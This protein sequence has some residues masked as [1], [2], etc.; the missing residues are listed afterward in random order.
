[1]SSASRS[2][3]PEP[4]LELFPEGT[5]LDAA[6]E[7]MVGG[8][9]ATELAATFGTPALII[10]EAALR[11]RVRRYAE[12]LAARWPNSMVI[13]ASKSLPHTAMYRLMSEE[14]LGID[15]AGSGELFM[16][17][18][19]D[20]DP[21]TLVL[22]GNAKTDHEI[23]MAVKAGVGTIVVDSFDDIDR[24]ERFV[25]GEQGVLVRLRPGIMPHTHAAIATG[26]ED[27]KFGLSLPDAK[28]AVDRLRGSDKLRLD[29]VHVHV[30][31]QILDTE[32]FARAVEAVAE[33]GEYAVY[34][35][36]GGL[37]ARYT[38]DDQP[39]S[40]EDYLDTLTETA[41]KLLPPEARLLI[42]PGRSL[43]AE[44]G[45]TL[46]RVTTVKR[47]SRTF[48]AVDGGMSD[49]LEVSLYGQRFEATVVD[50]V[51]GGELCALVGKHCESGDQ[52]IDSV[53]LRDPHAGDV[54]AVPVTGAYCLTMANNYNG[55]C[56]PPI[57]F[58]NNGVP[59]MIV[60]RET[61]DD[62]LRRDLN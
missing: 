54:I 5:V 39:P 37:G 31:S 60:R 10:G 6:G 7:L 52:L 4:L 13:W 59:R 32:P 11:H 53:A 55:S 41:S 16:A 14:G 17:L 34:N 1:M 15:V 27:S 20:A 58:V 8:C 62:L 43:V 12:G 47:G 33:M 56:R 45:V 50:K 51:G 3:A 38:R 18:A 44:V 26:Q 2:N 46:Y 28:L 9:S 30:G 35:L 36:G 24:L 57:I 22:H 61:H 29:G 40:I 48:V 25:V 19:A 49:N 23:E 42:E 21:R